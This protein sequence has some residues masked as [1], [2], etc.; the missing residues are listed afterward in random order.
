MAQ[1]QR[2]WGPLIRRE[3]VFLQDPVPF[4]RWRGR[5]GHPWALTSLLSGCQPTLSGVGA[6]LGPVYRS[7]KEGLRRLSLPA[8]SQQT[9]PA[10]GRATPTPRWTEGRPLEVSWGRGKQE[11]GCSVTPGPYEAGPPLPVPLPTL[12]P[13][14]TYGRG[15]VRC[16]QG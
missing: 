3:D 10:V 9:V 16:R 8:A 5:R 7:S 1:P 14:S 15:L 2:L 4:L 13:A 11:M 6:S 12:V